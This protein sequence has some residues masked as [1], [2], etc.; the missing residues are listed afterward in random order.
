MYTGLYIRA[1]VRRL[2]CQV[3]PATFIAS[4]VKRCQGDDVC[5]VPQPSTF[6]KDPATYKLE[7]NPVYIYLVVQINCY[8]SYKRLTLLLTVL[9]LDVGLNFKLKIIYVN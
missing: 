7:E 3:S 5:Q 9:S 1:E 4:Q 6:H 2:L 8:W